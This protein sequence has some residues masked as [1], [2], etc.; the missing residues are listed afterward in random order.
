MSGEAGY[1]DSFLANESRHSKKRGCIG[2]CVSRKMHTQ[3]PVCADGLSASTA[4]KR[5]RDASIDRHMEV[6]GC[7][8]APPV[9]KTGEAEHLGLAGSIPVRLRQRPSPGFTPMTTKSFQTPELPIAA[10]TRP[11]CRA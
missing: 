10:L 6:C 1:Y 3:R 8:V 7:L 9:F 4:H 11:C 5:R 2:L